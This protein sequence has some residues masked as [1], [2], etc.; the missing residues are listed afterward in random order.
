MTS[1][2]LAGSMAEISKPFQFKC[3][4]RVCKIF[5]PDSIWPRNI[6]GVQKFWKS[7]WNFLFV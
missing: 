4:L 3:M 5:S 2:K 1:V 6:F 7:A